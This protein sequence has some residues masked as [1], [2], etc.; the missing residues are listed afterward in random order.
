MLKILEESG[1]LLEGHFLLSSGRHSN[2]YVQC[3][4][5]LR[6]P[7]KAEVILKPVADRLKEMD[8]DL[9]VGPAMGGIIVAYELG[10]QLN[11]EAI[12][13]ERVNG[14]MRLRRGFEIQPGSKVAICEDVVTTAKSSREV[15]ALLEEL[16]AEVVAVASIIDRTA[17]NTDFDII[18]S[19]RLTIDTFDKESCPMCSENIP[20]EKPGSR[21]KF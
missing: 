11:L 6:Y 5:V 15:K 3:A 12:F 7:E 17:G 21:T 18:S 9:L 14:E 16:G 20:C 4:K 1:A 13:T 2:R 10:R 19:V 8:L